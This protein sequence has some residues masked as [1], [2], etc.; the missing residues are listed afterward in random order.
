MASGT[1]T[2]YIESVD[3]NGGGPY[4]RGAAYS[5]LVATWNVD[6]N[7][8]LTL[9]ESSYDTNSPYWWICSSVATD[10]NRYNVNWLVQFKPDGG[11][12]QTLYSDIVAVKGPCVNYDYR[13]GTNVKAMME[14]FCNA[15]PG[16]QLTTS[17][18][19]RVV[20]GANLAPA[21]DAGYPTAFPNDVYS[22]ASQVPVHIDVSWDAKLRY[23]AN[24]GSNAP[25]DVTER[26]SGSSHTFTVSN[27]APTRKHFIF[28]GWSRTQKVCHDQVWYTAADA[29]I[30]GGDQVTV[31][32]DN[33]RL[34]L[35]AVWEY[36]Y[37]PGQIRQGGNWVDCDRDNS[38][39]SSPLGHADIRRNGQW[40]EMRTRRNMVGTQYAPNIRRNNEWQSQ[41]I[42]SGGACHDVTY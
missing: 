6:N 7:G 40:V 33:P 22:E 14:A 11:N 28:H 27:Q 41:E 21:P 20:C 26:E 29:E 32:K 25:A 2:L 16:V 30:H 1:I 9:S 37:R 15:F 12:W 10:I 38:G 5:N 24:G 35:Y 42:G 4:T 19:L 8:F 13:T 31:T 39:G 3:Y 23:N 17:G 36:T 18:E 34:E